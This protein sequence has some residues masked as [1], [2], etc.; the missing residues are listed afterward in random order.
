MREEKGIL[1]SVSSDGILQT[2]TIKRE[3]GI[4]HMKGL[5][6][7]NAVSFYNKIDSIGNPW[8]GIKEIN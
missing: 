5:I 8:K 2:P 3:D 1:L 6:W 4:I 7:D